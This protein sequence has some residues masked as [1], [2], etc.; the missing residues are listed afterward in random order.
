MSNFS[1][2]TIDK[3]FQVTQTY[4]DLRY[5][6]VVAS[7]G[8]SALVN[9]VDAVE[10]ARSQHTTAP[11][12][13]SE[14]ID[15]VAEEAVTFDIDAAKLFGELD[16]YELYGVETGGIWLEV[17]SWFTENEGQVILGAKL[18]PKGVEVSKRR[19]IRQSTT[20]DKAHLPI[21][22][23]DEAILVKAID[24]LAEVNQQ[25]QPTNE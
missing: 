16:G 24:R 10:S 25:I 15:K 12:E 11:L 2:H 14:S 5:S 1:A 4:E 18:G 13:D 19:T 20:F 23:E 9:A 3:L 21:E 8:Q 17:G 22:F 7:L 6:Y